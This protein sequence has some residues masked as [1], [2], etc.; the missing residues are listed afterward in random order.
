ML[1]EGWLVRSRHLR[2][3]PESRNGTYCQFGTTSRRGNRLLF[4]FFKL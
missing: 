1:G 3:M 2:E 4:S